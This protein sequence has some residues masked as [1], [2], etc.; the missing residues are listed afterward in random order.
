MLSSKLWRGKKVRLTAVTKSDLPVLAKW[1]QDADFQ[2]LYDGVP[3]Y[4]KTAEQLAKRVEEGQKGD[5][6][7]LFAIRPTDSEEIV[8]LL[9]FDGVMWPH[10]TTYVSIGIGQAKHRGQGYGREAMQLALDYA[11]NELNLHRVSLTVFAYNEPAIK[12][13]ESLGFVREGVYRE[14]LHR[15]GRR[16]HMYLYG[17]LR[18]EWADR[19]EA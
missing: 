2:R 6:V 14:A 17:I 19:K 13:Y 10:G 8:G 9:E 5:T 12:L 7:F 15:D 18:R 1:W 4:P 3:A 16:Y 11:F